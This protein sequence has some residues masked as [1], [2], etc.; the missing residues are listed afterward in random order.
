M[1]R[2]RMSIILVSSVVAIGPH[3]SSAA[4]V[5]GVATSE[6]NQVAVLYANGDVY[7]MEDH[8]GQPVFRGSC[9]PK[10]WADLD[11]G[12]ANVDLV[13]LS[14]D[15]E[16]WGMTSAGN[17]VWLIG[18]FPGPDPWLH[19]ERYGEERWAAINAQGDLWTMTG[20][21]PE[22]IGTFPVGPIAVD[23]ES[24]SSIKGRYRVEEA[25]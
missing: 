21:T 7:M 15:G 14:S 18:T 9:G 19:I 2:L 24:W 5:L 3:G 25:R 22:F 16:L 12:R 17:I 13:A 20:S 23:Q 4:Q 6:W 11:A 1:N 10:V 8:V